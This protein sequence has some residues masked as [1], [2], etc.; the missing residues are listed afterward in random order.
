MW[1]RDSCYRYT[2]GSCHESSRGATT[3]SDASP[4]LRRAPNRD[5]SCLSCSWHTVLHRGVPLL[6]KCS[7]WHNTRIGWSIRVQSPLFV[8]SYKLIHPLHRLLHA[9]LTGRPA[10]H[11][12][13]FVI[14]TPHK[15]F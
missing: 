15:F 1:I 12:K 8:G 3:L 9:L 7:C 11:N 2:S 4:E 5:R 14:L 13:V 6:R 10:F